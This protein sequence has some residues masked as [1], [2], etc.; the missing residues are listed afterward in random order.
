MTRVINFTKVGYCVADGNVYIGRAMP[1]YKL[2]ASK[3]SNKYKA[4]VY[5]HDVA[6]AKYEK[7]LWRQLKRGKIHPDEILELDGKC[8]VCFCSPKPCHGDII[9]KAIEWLKLKKNY[10]YIIKVSK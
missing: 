3:F 2:E 4:S 7:W 9:V 5:G 6:I 8:L 1:H 10:D